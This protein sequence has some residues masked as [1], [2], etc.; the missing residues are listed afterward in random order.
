VG[1]GALFL[2]LSLNGGYGFSS[3]GTDVFKDTDYKRFRMGWGTLMGFVFRNGIYFNTGLQSAFTNYYSNNLGSRV[4]DFS[5]H[6][7]SIGYMAGS[8]ERNK[9]RRRY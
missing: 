9:A 8:K 3:G 4:F 6:A 2:N 5:V 1:G 7:L